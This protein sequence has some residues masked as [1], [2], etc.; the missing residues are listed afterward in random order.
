MYNVNDSK[1]EENM[2][3]VQIDKE[4]VMDVIQF[5]PLPIFLEGYF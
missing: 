2:I 5:S 3:L 1:W 4:K